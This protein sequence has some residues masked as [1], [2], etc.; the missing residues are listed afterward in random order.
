MI[1]L[2]T[3]ALRGGGYGPST[4]ATL[5]RALA[6]ETGHTLALPREVLEEFVASLERDVE[7]V[8]AAGDVQRLLGIV[9]FWL[10]RSDA[11][12]GVGVTHWPS[13]AAVLD[14]R[15][16]S[17]TRRL[18][19]RFEILATPDG[20]ADEAMD[21]EKSRRPPATPTGRGARDVV[22]WLTALSAARRSR[23]A[24]VYFVSEDRGFRGEDDRTLHHQ[25]RSE[26]PRNLRFF[27]SVHA[28]I[29]RLSCAADPS[30]GI[31]SSSGVLAAIEQTALSGAHDPNHDLRRDLWDWAPNGVA[32]SDLV[33][34]APSLVSERHVT[35]RRCGETSFTAVDG[36]YQLDL[37]YQG[38]GAAHTAVT[39][40]LG[41]IVT[42]DDGAFV[43]ARVLAR[44]GIRPV[45]QTERTEESNGT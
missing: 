8:I 21:R 14:D 10:G 35:S 5:L 1:V 2:D 23:A 33:S 39:A 15:R 17:L 20:A 16:D 30:A 4:S 3:N 9:P 36:V 12:R 31:A 41:V 42:E 38:E 27:P 29:D 6:A 19:T 7:P 25:L 32:C 37:R 22:V 18:S 28:L 24:N 43:G 44:S 13:V 26:A 40:R 11:A 34:A 45:K